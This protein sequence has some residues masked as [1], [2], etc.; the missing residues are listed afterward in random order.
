MI[1]IVLVFVSVTSGLGLRFGRRWP[2]L[3]LHAGQML[4]NNGLNCVFH[5]PKY[6]KAKHECSCG[7]SQWI[8][9]HVDEFVAKENKE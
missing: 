1:I 2:G 9:L 6:S 5:G 8:F 3:L 4:F 7:V